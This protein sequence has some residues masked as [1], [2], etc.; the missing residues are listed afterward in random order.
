MSLVPMSIIFLGP[1]PGL[2]LFLPFLLTDIIITMILAWCF[3]GLSLPH[4]LAIAEF[5]GME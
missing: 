4:S 1:M 5:S 2:L 3:L